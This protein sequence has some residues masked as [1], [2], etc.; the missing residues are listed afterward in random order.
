M[1]NRYAAV[2]AAT[3]SAHL[4]YLLYVPGGGFLALR[5]PRTIALH[6][7]AVAWG[8]AVVVLGL[9]CPLTSLES[10]ARR[11]AGMDPLPA[12]GFIGRYVEDRF[13]P[14]GR[15]GTAQVSAFTLAA[16]SWAVA[17]HRRAHKIG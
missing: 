14:S 11:R 7:A 5:W 2:V 9:R 10:W 6:I 1:T 15:V 17:A 4:A 13:V 16:V 12:S 3:A 8:V